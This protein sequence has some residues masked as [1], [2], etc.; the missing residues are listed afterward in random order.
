MSASAL[1]Q[2]VI[3][4]QTSAGVGVTPDFALHAVAS[5]SPQ[6]DKVIVPEDVGTFAP[7]RHYI[8]SV[9]PK[10]SLNADGIFEEIPY[11]LSMAMGN[12]TPAGGGSP[13]TW[14][15][16]L[17]TTVAEDFALYSVEFTDGGTHVVRAEDVFATDL[18]ITGT[19]GKTWQFVNTLAGGATTYPGVLTGTPSALTTLTPIRMADTVLYVDAAYANVGTTAVSAALIDFSWKLE[20]LQHIKQFAG[21][22]YPNGR[23]NDRWKTTLELTIEASDATFQ[24]EA[25]KL[26]NT[27]QTALQVKA[28]SGSYSIALQG[29][30]MLQNWDTL[31]DRDGNNTVK[32]TYVGEQD[33][34]ANTGAVVAL[35]SLAAL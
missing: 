31:D 19:A 25:A 22:L 9:Q 8:G 33:A 24:T 35:S 6:V 29:M 18:T 12:V 26:L 13:Y 10:G 5:L 20:G 27:T 11:M 17:P 32:Y 1:R 28:T 15:F 2:I 23:G 3:G 30:F 21:S 34:S 7:V 16:G 14:T 4:L